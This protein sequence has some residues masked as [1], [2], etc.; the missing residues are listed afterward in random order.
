VV[1]VAHNLEV[2]ELLALVVR[3]VAVL[4]MYLQQQLLVQLTQV[5]V[6]VELMM[7]L[8]VPVALV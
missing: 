2:G 3:A 4:A 7:E 5:A 1:E 6:V 8:V